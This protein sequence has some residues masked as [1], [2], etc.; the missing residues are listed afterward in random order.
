MLSQEFIVRRDNYS[1][2]TLEYVM[3]IEKFFVEIDQPRNMEMIH[4]DFFIC[5]FEWNIDSI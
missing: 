4:V 3:I 5:H 2:K 1:M